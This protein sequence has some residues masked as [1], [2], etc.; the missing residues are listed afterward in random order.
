M[1]QQPQLPAAVVA[2]QSGFSSQSSFY[3]NFKL[4]KGCS[5]KDYQPAQ[6]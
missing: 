6:T 1:E 2:S 4:Y 5:P 3:R